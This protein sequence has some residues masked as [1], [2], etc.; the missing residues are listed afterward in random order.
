MPRIA[1][2]IRAT[3]KGKNASAGNKFFSL[4][5]VPIVKKRNI[6]CL[7]RVIV[8]I[9][10]YVTHMRNCVMNELGDHDLTLTKVELSVFEITGIKCVGYGELIHFRGGNS[11]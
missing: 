8:N 6:L 10:T 11:V 3:L 5:T 7:C 2:N 9:F 4:R 1:S